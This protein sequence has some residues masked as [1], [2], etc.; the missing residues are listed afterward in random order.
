MTLRIGTAVATLLLCACASLPQPPAASE[1]SDS[2]S[3]NRAS[4]YSSSDFITIQGTQF[5]LRGEPYRFVGTNLWYGAYLGSPGATGNR[6]RLSRELDQLK[7]IGVTNI[8]VLGLSEA[9]ELK[10]AVRPA[11]M[12]SPGQY[13]ED[14]LTGL[15]YLLAEMAQREMTAVIYLNN[16]WQ[17]S[18][19]MTQYVA[20]FTGASPL[21]PDVTGDWNGFMDNSAKFYSI[22]QAQRAF[23]D[24]IRTLITRRNTVTGKLYN[25]DPTIM[26]WQ[27]ANEPR[28]GSDTNGLTNARAFIDWL[29]STARYIHALAPKQLVSTGSEGWMGTAGDRAL[30]VESHKS[31]HIDYLTFHMWA[32]NW[33]WFDPKRAAQTYDSGW[34]KARDY[35]D[36]HIDVAGQL[37][38]PIVLEEF[39]MNRDEGSFDPAASTKYRDRYYR[40]VFSVLEQRAAEGAA[41]AGSNFW[42][43]NGAGRTHNADSM[44]K[45]GDDFV[46]DPPQ[47]AQGLYGVFD[48]DASTIAVIKAHAAQLR[49]IGQ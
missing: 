6:S 35:L 27:L 3:T 42:A 48:S 29:E 8:R 7:S 12:T 40:D 18:G 33:Q 34:A 21:D 1:T 47:E 23:K 46:G 41:I 32:P 44:W 25:E 16:F 4:S 26:S 45:P 13:D 38:K 31:P 9:S 24:A 11:I 10:R 30:Y 37:G 28:P 22:E 17:W 49:S 2:P 15:D 20:W 19:G 39:G 5:R 14:L 36:W 43:W